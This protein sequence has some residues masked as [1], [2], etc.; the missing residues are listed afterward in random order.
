MVY[1][2]T[3][4]HKIG[5]D[6]VREQVLELCQSQHGRKICTQMAFSSDRDE[7]TR[8]AISTTWTT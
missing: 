5:F 4:E 7:V 2:D 3:I 8:L 1:P 6:A